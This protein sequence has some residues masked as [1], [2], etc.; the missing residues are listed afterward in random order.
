MAACAY[1]MSVLAHTVRP[2]LTPV[3]WYVLFPRL[4]HA[5][6]PNPSAVAPSH[7]RGAHSFDLPFCLPASCPSVSTPPLSHTPIRLARVSLQ[8]ARPSARVESPH[9]YPHARPVY[10]YTRLS[11]RAGEQVPRCYLFRRSSTMCIRYL[12]MLKSGKH[13]GCNRTKRSCRSCVNVGNGSIRNV[14]QLLT[15]KWLNGCASI[16]RAGWLRCPTCLG[17]MMS[18]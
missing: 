2:V 17:G 4:T 13:C 14:L 10:R 5:H 18:S 6:T 1:S 11:K 15:R 16:W 7:A 12:H 8:H 9:A 3:C